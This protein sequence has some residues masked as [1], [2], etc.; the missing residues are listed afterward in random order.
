MQQNQRKEKN[1]TVQIQ[2]TPEKNKIKSNPPYKMQL[3]LT[4]SD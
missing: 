2:Q 4:K 3:N 1:Q